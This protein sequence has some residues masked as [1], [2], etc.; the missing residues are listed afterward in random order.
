MAISKVKKGEALEPLPHAR[1]GPIIGLIEVIRETEGPDDVYKLSQKLHF[2]LDDLL[3]ITEAAEMLGFVKIESGDIEPTP[4][5]L[6]LGDGDENQRK[7]IFRKQIEH[8]PIIHKVVERLKSEKGNRIGK[9]FLIE[10]LK[11]HFSQAETNRQLATALDWGR[12]AELFG[13]DPDAE[14][15]TL[16]HEELNGHGM[17]EEG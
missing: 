11:K 2:E 3:P 7:T 8:L 4:L 16:R 9:E 13:Y 12:Y 6:Q 5:G 14:E 1:I 10:I 15:F 17:D